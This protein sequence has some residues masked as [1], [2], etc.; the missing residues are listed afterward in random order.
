MFI[1]YGKCRAGY[2]FSITVKTS[3][4]ERAG[5][6]DQLYAP[7][8]CMYFF[9][10]F[11]SMRKS[12]IERGKKAGNVQTIVLLQTSKQYFSLYKAAVKRADRHAAKRS[13][14]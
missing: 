4:P 8:F 13:Y 9:N 7:I 5:Y 11:V 10:Q 1:R 3:L 12:F 6:K 14:G 2:I